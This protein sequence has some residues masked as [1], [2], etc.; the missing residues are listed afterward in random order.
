MAYL[1]LR[2]SP[3]ATVSRSNEERLLMEAQVLVL[4]RSS[5]GPKRRAVPASPSPPRSVL[6][7]DDNFEYAESLRYLLELYGHQAA[8]ATDGPSGLRLA[9]SG[10]YDAIVCDIGLPGLSGYEV[11]RRFR[12]DP[13]TARVSMIAVSAYGSA[14]AKRQSFAAG[15]DAHLVKPAPVTDI[16]SS[17]GIHIPE[18]TA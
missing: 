8:I 16:L 2:N 7:I 18:T 12:S 11:A 3:P 5:E 13:G 9:S 10:L 1:S 4:L 14:E 6:I 17:L 15:F